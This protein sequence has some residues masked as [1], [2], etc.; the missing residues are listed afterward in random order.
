MTVSY[1]KW[2]LPACLQAH[3][4][5]VI[6]AS[7][8]GRRNFA[9]NSNLSVINLLLFANCGDLT[10]VTAQMFRILPKCRMPCP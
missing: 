7:K 2:T 1:N 5:Q 8:A 10:Q 9:D 4:S 3:V 6:Q